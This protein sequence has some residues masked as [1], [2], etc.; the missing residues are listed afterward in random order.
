VKGLRGEGVKECMGGGVYECMGG[1]VFGC[2]GVWV[3]GC[4]GE[5]GF[6]VCSARGQRR[7][8]LTLSLGLDD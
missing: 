3:Y 8:V 1:G 7:T 5:E 6:W 2:M 4:M